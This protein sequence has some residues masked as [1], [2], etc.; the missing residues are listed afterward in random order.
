MVL[1]G[2]TNPDPGNNDAAVYPFKYRYNGKEYQD[3]LGLNLYDYGARNY[4][5][6]IG[7]WM[8]IDP[9]AETSRRWT[10]Y[11]Y[12]YN[13]PVFFIDPDGM[14]ADSFVDVGYGRMV[15]TSLL[16]MSMEYSGAWSEEE[17]DPPKNPKKAGSK[18]KGM[19]EAKSLSELVTIDGKTYHKN[20]TDI[21]SVGL[22]S[23]SSF[24]GGADDYFV[25]HK[26]YDKADESFIHEAFDQS[27]GALAGGIIGKGL[28]KAFASIKIG[29]GDGIAS[30]VLQLAEKMG[31]KSGQ[32][33]INPEIVE[34]YYQ[35]MINKTYK[36]TGGAGFE[37]NG[38]FVLTDGNHKMVAALRYGIKTGNYSYAEAVVNMGRFSSANPA[39]YGVKVYKLPVK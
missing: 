30:Q 33:G 26:A 24:F 23:V 8:N 6:A 1:K 18:P 11:N 21:F 35:Q 2:P 37:H 31:I 28:G 19:S 20:T 9:L 16:S 25:E 17:T 36:A 5:P 7:R 4:D 27:A 12:C 10:P 22:N 32:K 13:N 3:E 29:T 39:S 14:E 34:N 38:K 15:K